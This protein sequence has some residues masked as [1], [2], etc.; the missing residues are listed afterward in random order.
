M[1]DDTWTAFLESLL[2]VPDA[3][4]PRA[5]LAALQARLARRNA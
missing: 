4:H 2:H 5:L 3:L 1:T